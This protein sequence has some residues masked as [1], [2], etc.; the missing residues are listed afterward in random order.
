MRA[1]INPA[2]LLIEKPLPADDPMQRQPLID[3]AVTELD[4][5]PS[6]SLEQ[7]LQ[8]TIEWFKSLLANNVQ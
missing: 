8:P 2:L 1:R 6:I 4:W 3:L 7:G 5:K